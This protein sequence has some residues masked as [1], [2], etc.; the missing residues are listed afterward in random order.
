MKTIIT[1]IALLLASPAL[2]AD[3]AKD[4]TWYDTGLQIAFTALLEVDREQTTYMSSHHEYKHYLNSRSYETLYRYE[5]NPILGNRP[6]PDQ[7][8]AYFA[9]VAV[10]HA[11][12]SYLLRKTGWNIFGVPAVS[13]WQAASIG[14]EIN[15]VVHNYQVGVRFSFK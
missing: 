5:S 9:G 6:N 11:A 1:L 4:W 12:V 2:A 15:P 13:I 10:G 8:N 3:S 7:I 14:V